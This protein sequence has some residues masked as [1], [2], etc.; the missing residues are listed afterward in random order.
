MR[1]I[2][3]MAILL[4]SNFAVAEMVCI[5]DRILNEPLLVAKDQDGWVLSS[6]TGS[7]ETMTAPLEKPTENYKGWLGL[8]TQESI[9]CSNIGEGLFGQARHLYRVELSSKLLSGPS[10]F[11]KIVFE[12]LSEYGPETIKTF[13]SCRRE[14]E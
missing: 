3:F 12:N 11:L 5:N 1:S 7:C 10:G 8:I 9:S 14:N 6:S 2:Q 4:F 13:L